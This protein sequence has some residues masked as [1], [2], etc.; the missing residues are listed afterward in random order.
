[1]TSIKTKLSLGISL[2]LVFL[3][4]ITALL[5]VNEKKSE[6]A[7]DIYTNAR[8]FSELTAPR[9][10][11]LYTSLLAENSFVLFNR[12]IRDIF[13]K[14]EDVSALHVYSFAGELLYDSTAEVD[15]AYRGEA[16]TVSDSDLL[17]RVKS[18]IPS[19]LLDSGRTVFLKQLPNGSYEPVDQNE[20]P[21]DP[22]S[23][24]E[25]ILNIV[26]PLEGTHAVS[27]EI[28]YANLQARVIRTTERIILLLIFGVLIGLGFAVYF[29]R[30]ITQ[31]IEKLKGEAVVLGQG[32]F[33][34][35]VSIESQDEVG[36]LA[37]T[38]NTMARDLEISTKAMME[39]QKL[40]KELELAAQMQKQI[41]PKNL[42]KIPGLQIATALLPAEEVG[43]DCYDIISVDD[44]NHIIYIG[45]VTGHGVPSALVVSIA[46]ALIYSY[47][48]FGTMPE[49][50]K[51][52]NHV[53]HQKTS[54]N[55]FM[56]LLMIQFAHGKLS[57][58]SAGHPE[59]LHYSAKDK[60]VVTRD[61]GGIALG[62]VADNSKMLAE[63]EVPF[64]P[65]DCL[66]LYSDGIPECLS[67]KGVQ[68]GMPSF[69]RALADAGEIDNVEAIKNA[70][71]A[72]VKLFSGASKQ[73]DDITLVVIRRTA[74]EGKA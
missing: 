45:D 15:R 58:V 67:E 50:L 16:R 20:K 64:A 44:D 39:R 26:Y 18:A 9:I 71:V 48:S 21:V 57:Y 14:N 72:D 12:E 13:S 53:L 6:L 27:Y 22:I 73:E 10:Q 74:D 24:S 4:T 66:V 49:L 54:Q 42:P 40:A 25:R 7:G 63:H 68:Y 8:S 17:A 55:M 70:L 65:G 56:T 11:E 19:Y 29:A 23:Q 43:G 32:N 46:N 5:L 69:K 61:S 59:M 1:M 51:N 60:T 52:V 36:Q 3:F 41:L 31:P 33:K 35:R 30:R 47:A 38:F 62:M 34:A 2:V 37:E 28:S